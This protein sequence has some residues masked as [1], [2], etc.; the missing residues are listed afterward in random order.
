PVT[1]VDVSLVDEVG[2]RATAPATVEEPAPSKAPED[3]PTEKAAAPAP[4][5]TPPEPAPTPAPR[6]APAAS[7]KPAE[8]ALPKPP[9]PTALAKEALPAK[10]APRAAAPATTPP[11]KPGAGRS[12]TATRPTPRGAI[13]SAEALEGLIDRPAPGKAVVPRAAVIDPKALAGIQDAIRRQIQPCADRQVNPGPGAN[14][15]VTTLNLR[16]NRD[17]SLAADPTVVRQSGVDDDNERYR[18]RVIDLGVAA[19]KGCSP[20]QLPPE[21]YQTA[22]G[23]WSNINYNWQLR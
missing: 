18:R 7:A 14:Q 6:P 17:G 8:V 2:L 15:I 5:P 10:P 19:F 22:N 21:F 13:V 12:A 9:K 16:L 11:A 3:G 4:A 23:G 1:P 20:L